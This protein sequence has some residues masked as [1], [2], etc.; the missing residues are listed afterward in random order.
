[1]F[2]GFAVVYRDSDLKKPK[3][4]KNTARKNLHL[5]KR[6]GFSI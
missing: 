6:I 2:C 1:M 3:R 4:R 5:K